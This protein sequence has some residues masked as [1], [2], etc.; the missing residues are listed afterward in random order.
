MR[1]SISHHTFPV[2]HE[3][4]YDD[5]TLTEVK[6]GKVDNI[7]SMTSCCSRCGNAGFNKVTWS[8]YGNTEKN[9]RCYDFN[10]N[11]DDKRKSKNG[12]VLSKCGE[13]K[14]YYDLIGSRKKR[15]IAAK[16]RKR[17]KVR[18]AKSIMSDYT[19]FERKKRQATTTT[20]TTQ[21]Y[22]TSENTIVK[23]FHHLLGNLFEIG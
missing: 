15:S 5:Y 20:T 3:V 18:P 21:E 4:V 11:K 10:K 19:S 16:G 6:I 13:K 23:I 14:V 8:V 17:I 22:F 9:C 2:H 12:Y 1:L 7:Q